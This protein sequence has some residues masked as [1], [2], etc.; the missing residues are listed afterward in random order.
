MNRHIQSGTGRGSM[1][2]QIVGQI[3]KREK[4]TYRYSYTAETAIIIQP[5]VRLLESMTMEHTNFRIITGILMIVSIGRQRTAN[6]DRRAAGT[7]KE[8]Q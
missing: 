3:Q 4:N 6:R 1:Y 8:V 7:V 2:G 5:Q